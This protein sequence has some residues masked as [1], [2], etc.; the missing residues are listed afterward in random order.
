MHDD[1][2]TDGP[3]VD[4]SIFGMKFPGANPGGFFNQDLACA[5]FFLIF[6]G[7]KVWK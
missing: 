3:W 2:E 4:G 5:G 1:F 6:S 7:G